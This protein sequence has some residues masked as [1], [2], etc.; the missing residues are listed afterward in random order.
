MVGVAA[1]VVGWWEKWWWEEVVWV[2]LCDVDMVAVAVLLR[3]CWWFEC[4]EMSIVS[5]LSY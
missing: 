4:E 1:V 5:F 3:W 2:L